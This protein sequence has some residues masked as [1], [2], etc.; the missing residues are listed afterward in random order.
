V[1]VMMAVAA[2]LGGAAP[3]LAQGKVDARYTVSL[4]G[5]P[6]GKGAW[7]IDIAEDR[8]TAATSGA[9]TGLLRVFASGQG[10]GAARG[11]VVSGTPVSASFAA[12]VTSDQ[13]TEEIRMSI[14]GGTVKD[15][16]INPPPPPNPE[17]VPVTDAHRVGVSDPITASLIRVPGHGDP[18]RPEACP[19]H[20]SIFDGR[21]RYD[22][23]L[24]YKRTE[25][26]KAEKGY[27][28]P[29]VVCAVYFQPISGHVPSRTAIKYLVDLREMEVWLVP[30]AGTRVVVPFRVTIPTPIGLGV[31]QATQ[32]VSL[33]QPRAAANG[34]RTQ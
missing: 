7:V 30:V 13:K 14:A 21:L 10:S 22:L 19:R 11:M 18:L 28:G 5:L 9:T 15:V 32:F 3:A 8:F 27:E 23:Q 12:S 16:A 1:L 24:A 34:P 29:A 33:P 25:R 20:V 6:I 4:A 17:R 31:L 2:A 26:V